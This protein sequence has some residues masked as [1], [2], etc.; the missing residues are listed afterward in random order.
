MLQLSLK[1]E[2]D[3]HIA[4]TFID[5]QLKYTYSYGRALSSVKTLQMHMTDIV[6]CLKALTPEYMLLIKL[7]H[8]MLLRAVGSRYIK[9][10]G[11]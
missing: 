9:V 7:K 4:S 10:P 5:T 2:W 6:L 1:K 3:F 8:K 11:M